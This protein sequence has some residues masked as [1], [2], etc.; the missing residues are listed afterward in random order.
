MEVKQ[1]PEL[2][3]KGITVR[4]NNEQEMSEQ[5][6][7][8][9]LWQ[10]FWRDF[11][12]EQETGELAFGVY[13]NYESDHTGDFDVMAGV[14]S[15]SLEASEKVQQLIIPAGKYL[16]FT[17]QGEMPKV[18]IDTWQLVWQC[19]SQPDPHYKRAY[20]TDFECY[21]EA[22]KVEVYIAIK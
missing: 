3:V 10:Q 16:M 11:S 15:T 19:F 7:I 5:G 22:D 8:P 1:L 17:N 18:V 21:V 20:T 9:E 6:K 4:T 14:N 2:V 13:T 12:I